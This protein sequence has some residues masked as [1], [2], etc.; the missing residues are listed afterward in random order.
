MAPLASMGMASA[1]SEETTVLLFILID[2]VKFFLPNSV[3]ST[4]LRMAQKRGG[5]EA[6]SWR[7]P[8]QIEMKPPRIT[9]RQ[10]RPVL[11]IRRAFSFC[12]RSI[13]TTARPVLSVHR[14]EQNSERTT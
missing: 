7:I 12:E 6:K 10:A 5:V 2:I 11:L 1:K 4:G 8:P 14:I 9:P 13:I 3:I